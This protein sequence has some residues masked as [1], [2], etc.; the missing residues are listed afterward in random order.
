[1]PLAYDKLPGEFIAIGDA[2]GM[3]DPFCGE[4]MR[5]AMESGML[6]A[7]IIA[8]G[9]RRNARYEEIKWQYESEWKG[10]W[11]LKRGLGAGMRRLKRH[12]GLGLRLAPSWLI[13]RMWD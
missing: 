10:R 12:F 9:I 2:A 8:A 4:G 13:N 5:H 11:M 1:G 3:M 7:K 6:A